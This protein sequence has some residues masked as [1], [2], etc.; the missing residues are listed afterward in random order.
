MREGN[1]KNEEEKTKYAKCATRDAKAQFRLDWANK[2]LVK[3]T[4]KYSQKR[5]LTSSEWKSGK[6][7]TF[8]RI[9]DKE[10]C[11]KTALN[12]CKSCIKKG[13]GY[14]KYD[15]DRGTVV[16]RY[17]TEGDS[18]RLDNSWWTE[19]ELQMTAAGSSSQGSSF[20][21]NACVQHGPGPKVPHQVRCQRPAT[22]A[23][24]QLPDPAPK[25]EDEN[26][27]KPAGDPN[28]GDQ[29]KKPK[30]GEDGQP[31]KPK[32]GEDTG[33]KKTKGGENDE[34]ETPMTGEDAGS[35]TTKGSGKRSGKET[36]DVEFQ[37]EFRITQTDLLKTMHSYRS[38]LGSAKT[39][40][41][42]VEKEPDWS[43]LRKPNP[44]LEKLDKKTHAAEHSGTPFWH[45]CLLHGDVP[46]AKKSTDKKQLLSDMQQAIRGVT[47]PME[48]L[49]CFN[50]K[51]MTMHDTLLADDND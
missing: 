21:P 51:L 20:I 36:K 6:W 41:G 39:I 12:I 43:W 29:P 15:E 2:K 11:N 26:A 34:P 25:V 38:I 23:Q 28:D 49:S 1:R 48:A 24:T 14:Y 4:A 18:E 46:A 31:E 50:K 7:L 47:K 13:E 3:M 9:A 42:H 35:K 16:F 40:L 19:Q 45:R 22:D 32:T 33:S 8:K 17:L 30:D 27:P 37:K 44:L 5:S 10:K